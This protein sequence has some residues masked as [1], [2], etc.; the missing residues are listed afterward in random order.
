MFLLNNA[1]AQQKKKDLSQLRK[2]ALVRFAVAAGLLLVIRLA[3]LA[4]DR[5]VAPKAK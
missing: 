4:L 2:K 5:T 1:A 3:P